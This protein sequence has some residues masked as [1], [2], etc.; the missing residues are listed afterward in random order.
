[1]WSPAT[2]QRVLEVKPAEGKRPAWSQTEE[3]RKAAPMLDP[4]LTLGLN[5]FTCLGVVF[6]GQEVS[7]SL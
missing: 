4:L 1:M 3:D 6:G 2:E 5:Q 7:F